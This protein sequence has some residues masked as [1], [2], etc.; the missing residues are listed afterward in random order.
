[1]GSWEVMKIRGIPLRIHPS[2]FLVFLYFTLSARNQFETLLDGQASIWNGWVIGVFTASLLFLS[3]LLHELAH[4]FVAIGEGLKVRDITLFFLGGMA[5]LEKECPTSKGSLKIA[6]SG[7]VVSLS[8]AFLMVLLSNNL[9][10]SNFIL[11]NLFKQVG[12]LNLLIGVFNL[13]PIM[14]LD[15]GVILKSLI[16]YF[17]GSKRAGIKAAVASAKLISFFAIF[18]GILSLLRGN[19]YI[20]LCFSI[21]GVLIFS[22]SKSQS[23]IIQVQ[24]ILSELYVNQVCSRSYRVLEDDLPVKVLSKYNSLNKDNIFNKEWILLCREGRWVGYVNEEILKN[25][26]VQNWDKKFLYEFSFPI[27]ELPSISE[28][29]SLWK[30][31]IKIE[32]TKDGRLLVLSVSGLP[33][34]TLDRVD[35]GKAVLKK[36]GLNLPDQLIKIARKENIYPL[37]LNLFNIAQSMLS[38]DLDED[39]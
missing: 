29:E 1:M 31:I 17:T 13:L 14:P 22:S 7:P 2:L 26:A 28:K 10:T 5:N 4:S 18:I 24:K 8:L 25:I 27:N 16:W 23:Q 38:S 9:S 35:I 36:I 34:G 21:I 30:A 39:Q 15:G 32:K 37:G 12:S 3:I 11:S 19:F 33:I 6:I 20:A